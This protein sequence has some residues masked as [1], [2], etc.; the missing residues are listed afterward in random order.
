MSMEDKPYA[1]QTMSPQSSPI[2]FF[3]STGGC[4]N[5]CL[6]HALKA[7]YIAR[8]LA[9]TPQKLTT[10]LLAQG[11]DQ[12]TLD[13][14]LTIIQGD[15]T[16]V[17]DVK[18]TLRGPN[19]DDAPAATIISGIG[20]KPRFQ[21]KFCAPL[22]MD[23]PNICEQGTN[24]LIAAVRDLQ[25]ASF[26]DYLPVVAVVSTTGITT[27]GSPEDVP[28]GL[29]SL[30]HIVLATP[31]EDKR[32]MEAA[33]FAAT[34]GTQAPPPQQQQHDV[35]S[36]GPR[37]RGVVAVKPSL[38]MGDGKISSGKGWKNLRVGTER[39]PAMGY[40]IQRADV[41]E[42]IFEEVVRN[43]GEKWINERVSVTA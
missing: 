36:T 31:H 5:A 14:H 3:G 18:R 21:A 40:T 37:F 20:A 32:K 41:G 30:Y 17:E 8:S 29:R 26:P 16:K 7:G 2:A 39:E 22:V 11:L 1:L 24:A 34:D 27:L 6:T 28:F 25:Q 12:A 35:K 13:K 9:R 10:L 19:G 42:W 23:N 38:L 15:V 33:L 4:T 43:G